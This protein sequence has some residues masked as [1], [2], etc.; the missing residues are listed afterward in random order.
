MHEQLIH[1]C[2]GKLGQHVH[3]I[4]VGD[5]TRFSHIM[6]YTKRIVDVVTLSPIKTR[7]L[8]EFSF[9]DD[10]ERSPFLPGIFKINNK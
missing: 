7:S 10:V 8:V 5:K 6:S 3:K 4:N 9:E 2:W 1:L